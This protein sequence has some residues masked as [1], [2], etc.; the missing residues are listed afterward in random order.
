MNRPSDPAAA[1]VRYDR[2]VLTNVL[3]YHARTDTSGCHCGW[4][5]LGAS[6]ADHVA[7][8]YE[9]SVAARDSGESAVKPLAVYGDTY[10]KLADVIPQDVWDDLHE[11]GL[12][13]TIR[14]YGGDGRTEG[15]SAGR[16]YLIE[17]VSE[18][19]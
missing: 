15:T 3:I 12:V 9:Q 19:G 14:E 8:V 5:V 10:S 11:R 16:D 18:L 2:E 4:A 7:D 17:K 1:P 6:Y 13:Q